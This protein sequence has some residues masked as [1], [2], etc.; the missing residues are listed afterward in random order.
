[1]KIGA[2]NRTTFKA[3][4]LHKCGIKYSWQLIDFLKSH[5]FKNFHA[6]FRKTEYRG[7]EK[8]KENQKYAA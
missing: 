6:V 5:G 4:Y 1:M 8:V 3:K 7:C 2:V